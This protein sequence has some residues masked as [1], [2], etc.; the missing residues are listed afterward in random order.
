MIR[1]GFRPVIILR[2]GTFFLL[3]LVLK[4]LVHLPLSDLL[5]DLEMHLLSTDLLS[6]KSSEPVAV[7]LVHYFNFL[8][9]KAS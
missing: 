9:G 8:Q 5:N 3:L 2:I 6:N 4:P 7:H 1:E